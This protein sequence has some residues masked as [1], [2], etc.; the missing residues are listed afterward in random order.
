[1]DRHFS[2]VWATLLLVMSLAS[3]A[4][5]ADRLPL[6]AETEHHRLD[7]TEA[8]GADRWCILAFIENS[9]KERYLEGPRPSQ[10]PS[11]IYRAPSYS[12][13]ATPPAYTDATSL[14][15]R[16]NALRDFRLAT[17]WRGRQSELVFG[18]DDA[19][20][21]GVHLEDTLTGDE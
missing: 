13:S 7:H 20:Y 3:H 8:P 21:L 4:D 5:Q 14:M 10:P 15:S 11:S 1:M 12:L 2:A 16:L 9:R 17:L 6:A 18:V 19:G